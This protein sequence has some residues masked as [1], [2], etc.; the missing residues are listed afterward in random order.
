LLS[1]TQP[2]I[3]SSPRLCERMDRILAIVQYMPF[4]S[5][6]DPR[7]LVPSVLGGNSDTAALGP[8]A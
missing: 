5:L 8:V 1:Y 7:S 2:P 4:R 3:I 6:P